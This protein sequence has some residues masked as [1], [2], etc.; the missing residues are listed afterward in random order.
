MV[1]FAFAGCSK[2][3]NDPAPSLTGTWTWTESTRVTTPKNSQ[4]STSTSPPKA[5]SEVHT[6]DGK[7][8]FTIVTGGNTGERGTYTHSGTTLS[9]TTTFYRIP[10]LVSELSA[11]RLVWATEWED[12][13]NRYAL[14]ETLTR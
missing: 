6:F 2:S 5:Y 3:G 13:N 14:T 1:A 11:H 4:P 9:V 7:G 10:R 12:A 8:V